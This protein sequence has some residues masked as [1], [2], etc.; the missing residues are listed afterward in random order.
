MRVDQAA[1]GSTTG[2]LWFWTFWHWSR[3]SYRSGAVLRD[4][5]EGIGSHWDE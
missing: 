2:Y 3:E 1:R 4:P 5:I